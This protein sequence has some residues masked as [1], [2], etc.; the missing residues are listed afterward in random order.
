VLREPIA[1]SPCGL[2]RC[3]IGHRCMTRLRPER[4]LE[5]AE[6]LLARGASRGGRADAAGSHNHSILLGFSHRQGV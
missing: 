2:R 1:C 4:V 5:A 6:E 3:P